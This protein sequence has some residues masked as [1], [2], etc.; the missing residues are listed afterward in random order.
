MAQRVSV[1][2]DVAALKVLDRVDYHD[3]FAAETCEHRS[4]EQW[5]RLCFEVDPPAVLLIPALVL[6]PF[7]IAAGRAATTGIGGLQILRNEPENIVLGF[8]VTFGTPRIVFSAQPGRVVMSTLLRLDGFAGRVAWALI[9][10]L[11]RVTARSLVDHAAK[12]AARESI[13]SDARDR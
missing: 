13:R 10:P 1:P 8:N 11:H 5:A 12:V 6:A 3:A 9:A 2:A 7:G 4:A